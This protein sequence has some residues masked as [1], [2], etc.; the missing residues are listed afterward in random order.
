[1][2]VLAF[3]AAVRWLREPESR[4]WALAWTLYAAGLLWTHYLNAAVVGLQFLILCR[5][6]YRGV[7]ATRLFFVCSL[8]V[9]LGSVPLWPAILRMAE[10]GKHFG[11][12]PDVPVW[13][14]V[15]PLWWIGLPL[16]WLVARIVNRLPWGGSSPI[17]TAWPPASLW[18]WGAL[19]ALLV[20][21]VCQGS[22]ASL[23]NPR[24]RIGFAATGACVVVWLICRNV[25]RPAAF[26]GVLTTIAV[27]TF[28]AERPPWSFK[29]L[30][31]YRASEW[32]QMARRI[33]R[34]GVAGEPIFVQGGLG[35]GFLIPAYY[36]DKVFHDYTA[37]RM[38]RFYLK[39]PHPRYALPFL[40]NVNSDALAAY[41]R[42]VIEEHLRGP[43]KTVWV[44][45][46]TDTD[47]N[48]ASLAGIERLL[49][50]AGA[51]ELE[52]R[53]YTS[54][55]LVHYTFAASPPP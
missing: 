41:Y 38:G 3:H 39:T 9:F 35:E 13:E 34:E 42:G 12:Q 45:C 37:C 2:A 46:A 16:G 28:M 31:S 11:F 24:Y 53:T 18:V 40:W 50:E 17:V 8:A 49:R 10:E 6:T 33:E 32:R 14:D 29:R 25:R 55:V 4:R 51:R 19:P 7:R 48:Q 27:I 44:A 54:A 23:A 26:A 20:P 5:L 47:L 22:L 30:G 15:R 21:V 36:E 1:L 52:R 43:L